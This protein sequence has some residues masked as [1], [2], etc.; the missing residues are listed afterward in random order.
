MSE[1]NSS[2]EFGPYSIDEKDAASYIL[3]DPLLCEDGTKVETASQWANVQRYKILEKFKKEEYGEILPRPDKMSFEL[4]KER[5]DALGNTAIRKE[6]QINCLMNNGKK[7]SFIMLLYIPKNAIKPV[8]AF[9]GLNFN[10]NHNCDDEDDIICTGYIKP[11]VLKNEER[12]A[13]SSRFIFAETIKKGYASATVCYHD[14]HPDFTESEQYSAFNLFFDK[15]DY[16]IIQDTYSVIGCWAWGLSRALDCLENEPLINPEEVIVHGHSR[17]GK[18]SLWAGAIDQRFRM[19]ISNNSG[20]G[21][22]TLHKRKFGENLSQHFEAHEEWGTPAWF[23]RKC[24][25]YV[26]KEEEMPFDQHELLALIAPRPL[27]LGTAEDD[28]NADPKGE[29]LALKAAEE[30]YKLFGSKGINLKE[31]PKVNSSY[32]GDLNF[33][34][35]SGKHAMLPED[36]QQYF[37]FVEQ[38]LK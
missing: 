6:I 9:L 15:K 36:W 31:M 28:H 1:C 27:A 17:L 16:P 5:D 12:G 29:F 2:R 10:G 18:T 35:R 23:V 20:C 21:G 24:K 4:L 14:I 26:W 34:Y 22:A 7:H 38:N 19:V 33:H 11:G 3:P 32:T 30:V 37:K 25:T 13:Q 8:P